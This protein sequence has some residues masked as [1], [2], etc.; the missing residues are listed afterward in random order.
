[1]IRFH[2]SYAYQQ[3]QNVLVASLVAQHA[4]HLVAYIIMAPSQNF[5]IKCKLSHQMIYYN[6]FILKYQLR[7]C[8]CQMCT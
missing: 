7:M 4:L 5:N 6:K 1:M 8:L 2:E 3:L